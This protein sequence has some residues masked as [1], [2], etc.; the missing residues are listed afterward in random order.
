MVNAD[1]TLKSLDEPV[2]DPASKHHPMACP[3]E[4][5]PFLNGVIGNI[6]LQ[7][8]ITQERHQDNNPS[9]P[10]LEVQPTS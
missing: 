3:A 5:G 10:V 2:E 6:T 7:R 9:T 4:L 1:S 8:E